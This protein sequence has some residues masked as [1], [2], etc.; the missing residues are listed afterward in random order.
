MN[1]FWLYDLPNTVFAAIV[2]GFFVSIGLIGQ[3]WTRRWVKRIPGNDGRYNELINATV[4]TVGVFFGITLGLISVGAWQEFTDISTNVNQEV[5]SINVLYRAVSLYP[6]PSRDLLRNGLKEYVH[7]AIY[8]EWPSQQKGI[9]PKG[10]TAKVT[11]FQKN[12]YAFEPVS[13]SMKSVHGETIAA[14]NDMI[15]QR[16]SRLQSVTNGL[17]S[18]LWLVVIFGSLLNLVIPW[19]LVYDR[20]FMQDLTIV[21]TAATIGLLVFLMAAMDYPF[22]GEF[23]VTSESFQLIYD[24]MKAN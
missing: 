9:V 20:Q 17:P 13:E 18:T 6:D 21:L 7:Y 24:R 11:A 4:A 14:F 1:L 8:E 23:S 22:R 2:I 12:L 5:S 15:R 10:G 16:R 19:L 3:R